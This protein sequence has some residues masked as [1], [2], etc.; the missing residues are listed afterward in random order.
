M[1]ENNSLSESSVEKDPLIQ[2]RIWFNEYLG[3]KP[4]N[5]D[6]VILATSSSRGQVS[7][8]TVYMKN[9]EKNGFTFYTNI[10]SRKAMHLSANPRAAL[11]FYWPENERQVRVEGSVELLSDEDT[12][13]YFAGRPRGSQL[14]AWASQ[15]SSI[16][17]DRRHLESRFELFSQLFNEKPVEKPP[18]WGGYRIIPSWFE[19]WQSRE[20]R[21]HDRITYTKRK[22][23]WI[24][25]RLAP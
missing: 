2:F 7:V 14:G 18:Y 4:L 17:P 19:F 8:R 9:T 6:A 5:P 22:D 24:I 21:L 10:N 11:L 16:I 3:K 12:S 15:Q 25:E 23:L 1:K 20:H 13:A